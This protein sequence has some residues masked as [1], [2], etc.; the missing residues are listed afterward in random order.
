M[1]NE[2]RRSHAAVLLQDGR[3]LGVGGA[4]NQCYDAVLASAE[5]WDPDTST[6]SAAGS[7]ADGRADA[8][9][10]VLLDGGVLVIG[11]GNL[12]WERH[13]RATAEAWDP[14]TETFGFAASLAVPRSGQTATILQD[15][16]VLVVGGG[17]DPVVHTC[18]D[19]RILPMGSGCGGGLQGLGNPMDLASAKIYVPRSYPEVSP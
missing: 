17:T 19:G 14:V 6:F 9:A 3:V 5:V 12:H 18:G 4:V 11:G 1:L 8:T 16:R 7:L 13:L 15:G 10:T 2:A